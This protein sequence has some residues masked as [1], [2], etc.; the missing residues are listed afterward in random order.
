MVGEGPVVIQAHHRGEALAWDVGSVV[1]GDQAVRVGGVAD[2]QDLHVGGRLVV[3]RLAL[4]GED[5]AVLGEQLGA[6]HALGAGA[7]ADQ[8]R[9]VDA[10][11]GVLGV[12]VQVQSLQQR[13]GAVDEL[14]R[15]ALQGAHGLRD[16]Q[17]AQVDGLVRA[18]Q[19]PAGDAEHNAVTDLTG[20]AG[21][22]DTYG[23]AHRVISW[24]VAVEQV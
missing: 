3:E 23:I 17:Q 10:V 14:H 19:L 9:D 7:G 5:L 4:T 16:L 1:H 11:E 2:D 6:L 22:G 20:C 8:Q 24:G 12:V 21:H 15:N 13:E 18:Q